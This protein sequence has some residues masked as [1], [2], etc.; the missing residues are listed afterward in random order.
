MCFC[1][2]RKYGSATNHTTSRIQKDHPWLNTKEKTI[3]AAA[4]RSSN[5][6]RRHKRASS[7]VGVDGKNLPTN[8]ELEI[9]VVY[10]DNADGRR[11]KVM[12]EVNQVIKFKY[13]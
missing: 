9:G 3:E 5:N 7:I 2:F 13:L 10:Q 11:K 6:K 1:I 4:G 8:R 12:F